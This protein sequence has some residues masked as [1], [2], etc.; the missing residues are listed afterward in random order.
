MLHIADGWMATMPLV[1]GQGELFRGAEADDLSRH[2]WSEAVA[3]N[4]VDNGPESSSTIEEASENTKFLLA[5]SGKT[6]VHK[7]LVLADE[8]ASPD[9]K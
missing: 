6:V 4:G 1:L 5:P 7:A 8:G 9:G 3:P 2:F